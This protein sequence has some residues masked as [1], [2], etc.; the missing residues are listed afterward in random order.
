MTVHEKVGL[1]F[2]TVLPSEI[3]GLFSGDDSPFGTDTSATLIQE[4]HINHFNLLAGGTSREMAEAN[5]EVQQLAADTRLGIPVTLSTDPRH[6]FSNNPLASLLS[7]SFS[8]WPEPIGLAAIGDPVVIERFADIARQEYVAVG[9]RV[10]LHPQID[11]ATEP[12][13]ARI[14]HTFGEDADLTCGL[15]AAYVRGFRGDRLGPDSVATMV[16]HFPGGGPQKDGEDPHFPYGAEQV[17]P[18]DNFDYHLE[19]FRA[20]IAAGAT[21]VMPYYGKPMDTP[22][23]EVGF[24][25]SK[26]IITDLL[27]G[28]LGFEGVV[29]T[30]WGLV[31]DGE[32][33]GVP[34]PARAWGVE[35][36]NELERAQKLFDAGV[37]QL[38]GEARPELVLEL[39]HSGAVDESRLDRSVRRILRE[40][41]RLGLFERPC[42]DIEA[43]EQT[44]GNAEFIRA[45]AQAQRD[46]L[47]LL[48]NGPPDL[49]TLPIPEGSKIYVEGIDAT[50]AE[51]YATVVE[52]PEE[53]DYAVIRLD[54][55]FEPRQSSM[56]EQ[57]FHAGSLEF[58]ESEIERINE[59]ASMAPTIA[60]IFLDRP[61]VVAPIV[62]RLASLVANYGADDGALLDV[63][64]GRATPRG[65]L[66]FDVPSSMEAVRA[67]SSDVP[68]DT[69]DPTFRFGDGLELAR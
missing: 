9:I 13:W 55:P 34:F 53:A 24:A 59:L 61:A 50:M 30:D 1:M 27:R 35:D 52:T 58:P 64:F 31:T 43:A 21:Q 12:R 33:G 32:I 66:P 7:G 5:N 68:F 4:K 40:K 22:H 25:F 38:G 28:E 23:E 48:T 18:G 2:H 20:A 63:T 69:A 62:D 6:A 67:G 39:I 10:A 46:S 26:T 36:L 49:P 16:K 45:G 44:V 42:V 41:F 17:Y 56:I 8:K 29:C 65:K 54:A 19:P 47:T 3:A 37:D 14:N 57:F 51:V 11:L 15:V 60:H